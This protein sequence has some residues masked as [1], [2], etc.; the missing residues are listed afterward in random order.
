[1]KCTDCGSL[2]RP[3][4][5]IDIDGTLADYHGHFL[6]FAGEYLGMPTILH[7]V[8]GDV[9]YDGSEGFKEWFCG[10]FAADERTWNDVKLAYRQGAQKRSAPPY[11]DAAMPAKTAEAAGAEVWLTTTR[12]HLRLDGIDPDTRFWLKRMGISYYGLL[13]D[14]D[15]YRVLAERVEPDRV[16]AVLDDLPEQYDAANEQFGEGTAILR[17]QRYNRGVEREAWVDDLAKAAEIIQFRVEH[18]RATHG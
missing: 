8:V 7:A 1:M 16:V 4:V 5:A 10:N 11:K 14:E 9:G 2:I 15:K 17:R 18:W 6:K 13:Y 3:V 12:P